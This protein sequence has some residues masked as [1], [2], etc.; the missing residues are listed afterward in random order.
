LIA[1]ALPPAAP[2]NHPRVTYVDPRR[3]RI[4]LVED[5][6]DT[7]K[8]LKKLL[9]NFGYDVRIATTVASALQI[10]HAERLD[11]LISDLGLP[12][13]TGHDLMRQLLA[14]FSIRGIALSGY[15]MEE[16]IRRSHQAGFIEHLTKPIDLDRLRST[17]DRV[18]QGSED[19]TVADEGSG[20]RVQGSGGRA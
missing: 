8:A 10:A 14:K 5:H 18:M 15:G 4:L 17:I 7:G 2:A 13:G 9:G 19:I 12:D 16:D 20:L 1:P 11:L 6:A 3:P